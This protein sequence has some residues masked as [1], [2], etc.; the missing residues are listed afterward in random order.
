MNSKKMK[1]AQ[2]AKVRIYTIKAL[3][4]YYNKIQY[5][6]KDT[7]QKKKKFSSVS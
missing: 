2:V 1:Q 7:M 6:K 4:V 5:S 3:C